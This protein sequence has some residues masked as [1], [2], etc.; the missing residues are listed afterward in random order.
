MS[1][2]ESMSS[3]LFLIIGGVLAVL[4]V[5]A[6]VK[7]AIRLL[8]WTVVICLI[9]VCLGVVLWSDLLDWFENL[10]KTVE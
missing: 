6:I 4:L 1:I 3:P 5:F 7:R 9:L 2:T 10:R 8:F